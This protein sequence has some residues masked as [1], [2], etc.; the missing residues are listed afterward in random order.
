M[1]VQLQRILRSHKVR[2]TSNIEKNLRKLLF[3][4]KDQVAT[5]DK[6]NIV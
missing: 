2:S 3:K 1:F 5:E 4:P 6:N